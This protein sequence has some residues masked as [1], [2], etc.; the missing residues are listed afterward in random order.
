[1]WPTTVDHEA[2]TLAEADLYCKES[3]VGNYTNWRLPTEQDMSDLIS[4]RYKAPAIQIKF[5]NYLVWT[6]KHSMFEGDPSY[7]DRY[8][9]HDAKSVRTGSDTE[10]GRPESYVLC[11]RDPA[12][13]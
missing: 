9:I 11:T 6:Q 8:N 1:M 10:A 12:R 3:T 5:K 4:R 2:R 13:R 7:V